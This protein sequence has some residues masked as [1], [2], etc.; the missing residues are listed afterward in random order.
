MSANHSEI[1]TRSPRRRAVIALIRDFGKPFT[2]KQLWEVCGDL[3]HPISRATL[4]RILRALRDKGI[5]KDI[6][7]SY[8]EQVSIY[9]NSSIVCVVECL[10]CGL[11]TSCP[12]LTASLATTIEQS[13]MDP[14]QTAI[15]LRSPCPRIDGCKRQGVQKEASS[16]M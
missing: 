9:A 15:F 7:L 8:G 10:S 2:A 4:Y 13:E 12:K 6:F 14:S 5:V 3:P 11:Y 1:K 16:K